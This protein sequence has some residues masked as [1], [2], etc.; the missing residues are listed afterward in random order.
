MANVE[1]DYARRLQS[2]ERLEMEADAGRRNVFEVDQAVQDVL[3]A[4][5][6]V[7]TAR[8]RH[9]AALDRFKMRLAL[10]T[11]ARI[12]L[13]PNE[14]E[15]LRRIEATPPDYSLEAAVRTALSERLDLAN[16]ADAVEDGTR[17]V[18][19]AA[20]NLGAELNLV[21]GTIVGSTADTDFTRLRFHEGTYSFGLEADLPLDRKAERNAYREAL[22]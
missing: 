12:E 11:D 15:A 1:N 17:K 20:D 8:Q 16:V 6:N 2:Q 9:E 13:D 22:I 18:V 3:R 19:V 4:Q 7:V 5:D 21:G 14:L 10:P